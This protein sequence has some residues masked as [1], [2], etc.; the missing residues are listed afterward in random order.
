M[1]YVYI[2]LTVLMTVYGQLVIKWQ[3]S[4]AGSLPSDVGGKSVFLMR[5]VLRPW[6]LTAF[7]A[8]FLAAVAWMA[9]MTKFNLSYAYPFMSFS[10]VLVVLLSS[11]IFHE[12]LSV[13][14]VIGLCLIVVG[15][16]VGSHGH[17][18]T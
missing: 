8:A 17:R 4:L 5:L 18:S 15:I 12:P 9:A 16:I 1:G 7:A 10:F 14:G 13:Q 6:I 11:W 3:V 2:A